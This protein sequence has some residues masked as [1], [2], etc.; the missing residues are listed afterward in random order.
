[1]ISVFL[2]LSGHNNSEMDWKCHE[3]TVMDI[4]WIGL[5]TIV[6]LTLELSTLFLLY[7]SI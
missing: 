7:W 6:E 1:M 5:A 2:L 4:L 3:V